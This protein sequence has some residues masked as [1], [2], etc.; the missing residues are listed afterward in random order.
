MAQIRETWRVTVPVEQRPTSK[1]NN[2]NIDNLFSVT[3]RDSGVQIALIDGDS[4]EIVNI[5]RTGYA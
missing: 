5:I 4:Y 1:Q 2:L 3:L